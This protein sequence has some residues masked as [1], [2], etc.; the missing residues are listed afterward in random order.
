MT[1]EEAT[2]V[3]TDE[4]APDQ[5]RPIIIGQQVSVVWP[6]G[7]PARAGEVDRVTSSGDLY[8]WFGATDAGGARICEVFPCSA[9]SLV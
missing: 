2:A 9:C 6:V 5:G 4:G 8:V 1:P 3:V 7:S